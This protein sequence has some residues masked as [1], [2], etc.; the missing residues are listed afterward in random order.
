[1]ITSGLVLT[2]SADPALARQAQTTLHARPELTL[3]QANK[4]WLPLV[5]ETADVGASRD[6][7]DWLSA[8]P[9]VDF[10]DVVQVNFE[11]TE[12]PR[13]ANEVLA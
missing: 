6:L 5:A 1:M 10:V 2:L 3:G 7:C 12:Q 11:E 9:G 4:R 13:E 8:L